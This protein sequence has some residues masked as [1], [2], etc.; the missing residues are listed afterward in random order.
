MLK[1]K[2]Y[3]DFIFHSAV[4]FPRVTATMWKQSYETQR[5]YEGNIIFLD[6]AG[7][8]SVAICIPSIRGIVFVSSR[9]PTL[10]FGVAIFLNQIYAMGCMV[11]GCRLNGQGIGFRFPE[12]A[13]D[14]YLL[15]SVQTRSG[16]NPASYPMGT[17]GTYPGSKAA[18]TGNR[19]LT[20]S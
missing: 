13:R 17:R 15:Y 7:S 5:C 9:R 6:A 4:A 20:Y 11:T 16:A 19:P 8:I 10:W 2:N 3:E 12:G 1:S 14:I 18:R